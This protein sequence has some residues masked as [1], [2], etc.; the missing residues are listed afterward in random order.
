VGVGETWNRAGSEAN[1]PGGGAPHAVALGLAVAAALVGALGQAAAQQYPATPY[2]PPAQ[3]ENPANPYQPPAQSLYPS[4]PYPPPAQNAVPGQGQGP[5]AFGAPGQGPGAVT[6]PALPFGGPAAQGAPAAPVETPPAFIITPAIE[7]DTAFTD[8]ALNTPSQKQADVYA[9]ISPSVFA[10]ADTLHLQGVFNY[11][12]QAI[13]HVAVSSQDQIIQNMLLNGTAT[14]VPE[15]FFFDA[16]AEMS[17]QSRTGNRGFGN[18]TQLSTSTATQT[19]AFSGSPYFQFH[20]GPAGDAELRYTFSQTLSDG[21]TAA[22]TSTIPGQ[23]VGALS[24]MTQNEVSAK[25]ASGELFSRMKFNGDADYQVSD[26]SLNNS[27]H[28]IV[29][30]GADYALTPIF[31]LLGNGGYERLDFPEQTAAS[32][33]NGNYVGPTYQ[34]GVQYHPRDDRL[35]ALNYGKTE[36]QNTFSGNATW[37]LTPLTTLTASYASQTQTEQQQL[38]Q[39]LGIA[40]Q[41]TPG[42]TVN[43]QT[44]LPLS[45]V[46]PNLP[47]QNQV[48]RTTTLQA[49]ALIQGGER[50]KY[51]FQF[52]RTEMDALTTGASSQTSNGGIISWFRDMSPDLSG[53]LSA[54]YSASTTTTPGALSTTTEAVTA[55]AGVSYLLTP[56]LSG[57]ASYTLSRQSGAGGVILVDLVSVGLHKSF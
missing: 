50:N 21:N 18:P 7:L 53:S 47:L 2:Q 22:I 40:T 38:L 17:D 13:E 45:F 1:Q 55:T 16:H 9:T 26:Q 48:T 36:G 34:G 29:T 24:N 12:P 3:P 25:Y 52:I 35:L 54:G 46:N 28:G 5:G 4:N 6:A 20:F 19:T 30:V 41:V 10:T 23:S 11:N 15:R 31:D 39:T 14:L 32:G 57:N 43:Q 51:T 56:T 27:R 42:Q 37:A 33:F 44:N 49:G 8:N